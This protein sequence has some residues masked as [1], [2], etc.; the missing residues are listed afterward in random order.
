MDNRL[1]RVSLLCSL[2]L[3]LFCF[4]LNASAQVNDYYVATTGSDSGPGSQSQPWKTITHAASALT[5]G[6]SGTTVHVA[7]GTYNECVATNRTGTANQ[8]IRYVSDTTLGAKI[9]C[10]GATHPAGAQTVWANGTGSNARTGDYVD[11]VGFEITASS[12]TNMCEGISSFG[13]FALIQ[14]NYV[15]DILGQGNSTCVGAGGGGIVLR[16]NGNPPTVAHD[17]VVDANIIDNI[18]TG[19]GGLGTNCPNVHGIYIASP[20][21]TATNNI[22]SRSCGWGIHMFHDTYQDVISNNVIIN[23]F[24]GGILV[25]AADGF[26]NDKTSVINNIVAHNGGNESGIEE[27]WGPT[28]SNNVYRNNVFWSNS[29]GSYN[30]ANGS[31]TVA[32]T[33]SGAD[34]TVFV[35]YTGNAKTGD[36]HLQTSSVAVAAGVVG[37]CASGGLTPCVPSTDFDGTVRVLTSALDAGVFA[38]SGS[39]ASNTAP[40]APSGLTAVVQ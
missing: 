11:I 31:R 13:A 4:V 17:S 40:A 34:S 20:R 5:L 23:N 12:P 15:H 2:V 1:S 25:S 38:V 8:R 10:N 29:P 37:G 32:G 28:G 7:Q 21:Q 26:T 35:K 30:F 33:M 24:N 18:G 39:S 36:Y 19:N 9:V 3:V 16:N 6:G 14:G 22:I 27:R